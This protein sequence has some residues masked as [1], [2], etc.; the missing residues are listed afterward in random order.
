MNSTL[1]RVLPTDPPLAS[2]PVLLIPQAIHLRLAGTC[3]LAC[4]FCERENWKTGD[5]EKEPDMPLEVWERARDKFMPNVRG[6]ELAGLGEPT[7]VKLFPQVCRDIV[8]AKKQLYFPTNG[9]FLGM[10]QV[11]DNVGETPRVSLSLDAWDKESYK[12]IRGGDWSRVMKQVAVF[13]R[14]KPRAFLHSQY[15]AGTYNIDG[16]PQFLQVAADI[17]I[18][19]VIMRFVQNHTQAREDVSL[20]FAKDRT[21]RAIEE[22]R[23]V[24]EK[25]GIWFTAERRPYSKEN[26]NAMDSPKAFVDPFE[27]LKRYLDF[28]PFDEPPPGGGSGSGSTCQSTGSSSSHKSTT[29]GGGTTT[30]ESD[31]IQLFTIYDTGKPVIIRRPRRRRAIEPSHKLTSFTPAALVVAADG[32]LWTCFARH[33]LGNVFDNDMADIVASERY[34]A[35]LHRRESPETIGEEPTCKGCA[36]VY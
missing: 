3:N 33:K 7:M 17:G 1:L 19:E 15:T 4:T 20:R 8:K 24:A 10:P 35:F 6:V 32:E 29:S 12:R 21:E 13:R 23:K 9:Y 14:E 2:W 36:R 27:K 25:E 28:A 34:Q 16:L 26:P 11:L 30:T 5:V 31:A 18:K 22:A